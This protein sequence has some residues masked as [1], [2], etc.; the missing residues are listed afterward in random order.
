MGSIAGQH[1]VGVI[2]TARHLVVLP[3]PREPGAV[4]AEITLLLASCPSRLVDAQDGEGRAAEEEAAA[5]HAGHLFTWPH[6]P[7]A[8]GKADRL[9][10]PIING[11][12]GGRPVRFILNDR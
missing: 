11:T 4:A 1:L 10:R 9:N 6:Q 3:L 12:I 5:Q 2:V 8:I 7:R